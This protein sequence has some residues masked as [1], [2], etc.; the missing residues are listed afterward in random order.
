[1]G[2]SCRYK[3]QILELAG[4]DLITI[5]PGLLSQLAN[6]DGIVLRKLPQSPKASVYKNEMPISKADFYTN[7]LTDECASELLSTGI[8]KFKTDAES[9]DKI[10]KGLIP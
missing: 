1:M 2:A 9:L 10:I 6:V 4:L 8:E 7:L 5:S 3:E